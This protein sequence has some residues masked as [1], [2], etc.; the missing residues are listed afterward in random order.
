M[1]VV[2][3]IKIIIIIIIIIESGYC[4]YEIF[5]FHVVC[6]VFIHFDRLKIVYYINN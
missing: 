6:V 3:I 5:N 4:C 1:V 2:I